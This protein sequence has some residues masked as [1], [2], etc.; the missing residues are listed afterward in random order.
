M[1]AGGIGVC[2][3]KCSETIVALTLSMYTIHSIRNHYYQDSAEY[4]NRIFATEQV[5]GTYAT[6]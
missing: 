1:S 3:Q 4:A 2:A 5:T 6:Q